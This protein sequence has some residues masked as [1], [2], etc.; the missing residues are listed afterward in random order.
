MEEIRLR[1]RYGVKNTL[2]LLPNEGGKTYLFKTDM[3][4]LRV[5]EPEEGKVL[6]IDP[7]GGPMICVGEVL[8]EIGLIVKSIRFIKGQG[9]IITF[10]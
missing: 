5:C 10:E 6:W 8:S 3:S 4:S 7:S 1:S 2:K 9:W